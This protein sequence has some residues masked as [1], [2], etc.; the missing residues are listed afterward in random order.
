MLTTQPDSVAMD[1]TPI[2]Q[3]VEKPHAIFVY[4]VTNYAMFS[5]FLSAKGAAEYTR[6]ET[7]HEL[8][9]NTKTV[10]SYRKLH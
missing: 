5:N 9:L 10:D 1:V 4:G 7:N 6:K 2:E 3:K 8:I